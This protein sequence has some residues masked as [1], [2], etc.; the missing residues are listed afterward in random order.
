MS[1][2]LRVWVCEAGAARKACA[3]LPPASGR[4]W[5]V[6]VG[7]VDEVDLEDIPRAVQEAL[8]G[9]VAV[10][11][12]HLEPLGAPQRAYS[13]LLKTAR[14]LARVAHG[15]LEDPQA[16]TLETPR[17]IHR[18][19]PGRKDKNALSLE[20]SWWF[21]EPI[22]ARQSGLETFLG[23]LR[24]YLPEALPRRYGLYEPPQ[25][26]FEDTGLEHFTQFLLEHLRD[27]LG[28]VWYPRRPVV[29]LSLR[30]NDRWGPTKK[31]FRANYLSISL[32]SSVL[33]RPGW[34]TQIQRFWREI[35]RLL[36]P[37]YGEAR[38]L[39]PWSCLQDLRDG[40]ERHPIAGPWFA[41]IPSKLATAL[42][43]GP[44][45]AP[46]WERAMAVGERSGEHVFVELD[47]PWTP[48][49]RLE[50]KAGL[51][52]SEIAQQG[53]AYGEVGAGQKFERTYPER[54]PLGSTHD[55]TRRPF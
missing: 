5:Q 29:G 18:F 25:H 36:R 30:A 7:A 39:Q 4:G 11:D 46:L 37:F 8:P 20:L 16:E 54:W 53:S 44:E 38:F 35:P 23:A 45:Y 52:P 55:P 14:R 32:E 17:G 43:L 15:V 10:I 33:E 50:P 2:D 1:Y 21:T 22:V 3:D 42:V 40:V 12:L 26:K 13:T 47:E 19:K 28:I 9:I 6:A 48:A 27:P 34:F 51:V 31:G 24:R 41:G 49:S